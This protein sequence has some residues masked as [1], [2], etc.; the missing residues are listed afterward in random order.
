MS[1]S[2]GLAS[3]KGRLESAGARTGWSRGILMLAVKRP[4]IMDAVVA[5]L[6]GLVGPQNRHAV[7]RGGAKTIS[8]FRGASRRRGGAHH[9]PN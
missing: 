9:F 7:D 3:A 2:C 8:Y 5:G 1:K 6:G 4:Q